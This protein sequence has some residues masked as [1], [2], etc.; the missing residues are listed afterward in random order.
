M[1]RGPCDRR[2]ADMLPE[3]DLAGERTPKQTAAD[4]AKARAARYAKT[5]NVKAMTVFINADVLA[6]FDTWLAAHPGQK[7]AAVVERLIKT[8]LL[9]KR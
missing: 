6:Q 9:R 2:T 5:H 3:H 7:R 4:L 1:T 8:Q